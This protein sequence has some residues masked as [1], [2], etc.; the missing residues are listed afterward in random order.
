MENRDKIGQD[1]SSCILMV[2]IDS[3]RE[4]PVSTKYRIY[5]I[6]TLEHILFPKNCNVRYGIRAKVDLL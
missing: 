6:V 5:S 2:N 1:L 4:L 3:A